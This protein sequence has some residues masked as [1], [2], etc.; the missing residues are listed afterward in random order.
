MPK[1]VK[2]PKTVKC[3]ICG[4]E[5]YGTSDYIVFHDRLG[6]PRK[7]HYACWMDREV[8]SPLPAR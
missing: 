8:I 5:I 2:G 4:E 6:R 1:K 7:Y 3:H